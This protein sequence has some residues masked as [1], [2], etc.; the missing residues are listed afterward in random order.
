MDEALAWERLVG[1]NEARNLEELKKSAPVEPE[2]DTHF[3]GELDAEE[4]RRTVRETLMERINAEYSSSGLLDLMPRTD[5]D[6]YR[7]AKP[8]LNNR[9][10]YVDD[11]WYVYNGKVYVLDE[12]KAVVKKVAKAI[13][14]AI[15]ECVDAAKARKHVLEEDG[16]KFNE[17]A[18]SARE[19]KMAAFGD[20]AK[21]NSVRRLLESEFVEDARI[22]DSN[23]YIAMRNGVIDTVATREQGELVFLPHDP[24]LKIPNRCYIDHDRIEG[25]T[26]GPHLKKV[27]TYSYE[28]YEDGVN[29]FRAAGVAIF[30]SAPKR[31][32]FVDIYGPTDSG[33]SMVSKIVKRL[34]QLYKTASRDHVGAGSSNNF[35]MVS[36]KSR[37]AIFAHEA[38]YKINPAV[39]KMWSGSD[40]VETDVKGTDRVEFMPEGILFFI[41]NRE[42]G[43]NMDMVDGDANHNRYFPVPTPHRFYKDG[44]TPNGFDPNYAFD[45]DLEEVKLP[46]EDE[47]TVNWMID[48]WVEWEK[49]KIDFIP[50][51]EN[52]EAAR[53]KKVGDMDLIR[54]VIEWYSEGGREV[55][56][57]KAPSEVKNDR[58]WISYAE[59]RKLMV[60]YGNIQDEDIP[61]KRDLLN[62][63]KSRGRVKYYDQYRLPGLV[64]GTEWKQAVAELEADKRLTNA[65]ELGL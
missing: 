44:L 13:A 40:S 10:L 45:S 41:S 60:S 61:S 53:R 12:G 64:L 54:N 38:E 46:S 25:Q 31:K 7:L 8:V 6:A 58:Q 3:T 48:L 26:P 9:L 47:I 14:K 16:R 59:F 49:L 52:Q 51:T 20:A 62:L 35:S 11:A 29:L 19:G 23:R 5:S 18:W 55:I 2:G 1:S 15:D 63:L 30:S 57:K 34:T 65:E 22:F 27:L 21:R 39:V 43:I 28:S 37:R 4:V 36:L 17:K 32:L 42:D 50:L 56:L 24:A 33:K